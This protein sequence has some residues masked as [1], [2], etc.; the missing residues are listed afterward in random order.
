MKVV[1]VSNYLN[2]HQKSFCDYMNNFCDEFHFIATDIQ[3]IQGY[4]KISQA[5]YVLVHNDKNK[6]LISEKIIEADFVIYGSTLQE[7]ISIRMAKNKLSFLYSERF[8]KRGTWRRWNPKT[9]I[10]L[11]KRVVKYRKSNMYVLCASAFLPYDLKLIGF[12]PSKCYKWG[13][14]PEVIQDSI[15]NLK[16]RKK[17]IEGKTSLLWVGRL[18][19]LKH[20]EVLIELAERLM[21]AGYLFDVT[22][23]GDGPMRGVIQNLID[24]KSLKNFIHLEGTKSQTEVRQFMEKS[25]I[26]LF[27]SS[28][29][30]G[31]GAV[32]N[33]AMS[34]GCTPVGSHGIGSVPYLIRNKENGLVYQFGNSHSFVAAVM[35]LLD[36]PALCDEMGRNAYIDMSDLWNAEVAAN[37]V[38]V[39]GR[40][41]LIGMK[42]NYKNGPCSKAG[43]VKDNW[44]RK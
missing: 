15:E 18:I 17:R 13:Y 14:F 16:I 26:F 30:E 38:L 34:S 43:V 39:L 44:L 41:L 19:E 3:N 33:E 32:L 2:H 25:N 37:R 22:I 11:Y 5:D 6:A 42:T 8:Y 27:T 9:L 4:Q 10:K 1:F 23:I 36:N 35:K 28:H 40:N 24:E 31:W 7:L 29:Q 20:P 21:C 12:P